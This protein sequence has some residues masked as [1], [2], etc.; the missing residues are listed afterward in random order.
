MCRFRPAPVFSLMVL[1]MRS[2]SLVD[3]P[4]CCSRSPAKQGLPM[5]VEL[6]PRVSP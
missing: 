4:R 1:M 6:V 5:P 3:E 2:M